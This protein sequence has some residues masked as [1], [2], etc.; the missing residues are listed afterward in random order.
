M[1][2]E[3]EQRVLHEIERRIVASDPG[4]ASLLTSP[5]G[6]RKRRGAR[7]AH[8]VVCVVAAIL[9]VLCL[10]L[11]QIASGLAALV[12]A[13]VVLEVRKARFASDSA[14]PARK[15]RRRL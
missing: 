4:L 8:D 14:R 11:G 5:H 13:A 15:T 7:V 1:L 2:S 9:G 12:F 6:Q 10:V 3:P